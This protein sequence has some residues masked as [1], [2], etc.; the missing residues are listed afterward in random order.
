MPRIVLDRLELAQKLFLALSRAFARHSSLRNDL[1]NP[2]DTDA[3]ERKR[4][5]AAFRLSELLADEFEVSKHEVTREAVS[6]HGE[7]IL[8]QLRGRNAGRDEA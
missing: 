5:F 8:S 6:N 4:D 7:A 3:A 1:L 2:R